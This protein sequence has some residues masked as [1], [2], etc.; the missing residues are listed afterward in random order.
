[1]K[2]DYDQPMFL[3]IANVKSDIKKFPDPPHAIIYKLYEPLPSDINTKDKAYVVREIIP[4]YTENV[5]LIPYEGEEEVLVL[6]VPDTPPDASPITKREVPLKSFDD[7]VTTDAE[8]K[9]GIIDKFISGSE[10]PVE[11]AI[12][13]SNYENFINFSSAQKRLE[14]F[15]Y[16]IERIEQQTALS[17]SFVGVTSG[18]VQSSIHRGEIRNIKNNFDGYESYLYNTVSTYLTSS[19]G[20]YK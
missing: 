3:L 1:M 14:N 15:K 16:K 6:K 17:S 4:Q 11:L 7:L 9:E 20:E 2:L 19:R 13:Y 18:S 12:E 8:L 10:K 5:E